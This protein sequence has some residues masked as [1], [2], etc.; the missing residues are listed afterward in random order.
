MLKEHR[1]KL[2]KAVTLEMRWLAHEMNRADL[3]PDDVHKD[4]IETRSMLTEA[5]KATKIVETLKK[6]VEVD[7]KNLDKFLNI[8]KQRE[9]IFYWCCKVTICYS[10]ALVE[11]C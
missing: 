10:V 2:E 8:L 11:Y 7:P 6:F 4:V 9:Q 1:E 3:L 5:E